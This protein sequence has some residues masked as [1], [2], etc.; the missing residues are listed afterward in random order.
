MKKKTSLTMNKATPRFKP[1]CT[2]KVWFPKSV[3][4]ATTSRNHRIIALTVATKPKLRRVPPLANPL[5]YITAE[6][7]KVNN[8]KDVSKGHGEGVTKWNG[9][10]WNCDRDTCIWI[11]K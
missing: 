5:K 1:F 2:A 3:P 6:R 9:W 11:N 4:S 10:P 7:V 8:A